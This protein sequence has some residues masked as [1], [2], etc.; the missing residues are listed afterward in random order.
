MAQ[1]EMGMIGLG[2]MGGGLSLKALREGVKVVG[3]DIQKPPQ[4]FLDAGLVSVEDYSGFV[5]HLQSP[6]IIFVYIPSGP[7]IDTIVEKLLKVLEKGDI[8]V[9]GGNSYWGDSIRRHQKYLAS[10]IHFLDIG[11]SGGVAV[12][13]D[14]AC[15]MLG[16][17]KAVVEK[18][19]PVLLKMA[20]PGGYVH[21]GPPGAGHFVKLV[22]NGI[23]YGMAEAVAEGVALL[24]ACPLKIDVEKTLEAYRHG[25]VIRGFFVD[26]VAKGY[27]D[28]KGVS[29]INSYV[30]DTGEVN[31]LVDDAMHM[32]VAIPSITSAVFQCIA[33]RDDNKYGYKTVAMLRNIYGGHAY[34]HS[35]V[36][37]AERY[38]GR[39][40]GYYYNGIDPTTI[41]HKKED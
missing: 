12:E 25:T 8:I 23:N 29:N 3:H 32:E 13:K 30:D 38:Q 27:K 37:A 4:K 34:G 6:R 7:M 40:G 20:M 31:W 28:N 22:H 15:F 5:K 26:T 2:R 16:G 24:E 19:E 10:G 39:E 35:A 14:G 17:D 1:L 9:D 41:V 21:A 36:S 11:T 33:S 18:V